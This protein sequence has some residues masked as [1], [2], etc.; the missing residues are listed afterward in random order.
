MF[1]RNANVNS[2]VSELLHALLHILKAVTCMV[3]ILWMYKCMVN[4]LS[5]Q[6]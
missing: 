6:Y 5:V 2:V 3:I 1:K 4:W